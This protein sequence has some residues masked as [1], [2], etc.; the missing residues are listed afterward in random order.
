MAAVAVAALAHLHL[1]RVALERLGKVIMARL[2]LT[3]AVYPVLLAVA[4]VVLAVLVQQELQLLFLVALV[5]LEHH[6]L[7]L[8]RLNFMQA[9]AAVLLLQLEA[10]VGLALAALVARQH[11]AA[12]RLQTQAAVVVVAVA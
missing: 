5:V 12:M 9:V 3:V 11:L 7:F 1:E 6:H 4:V 8:D 2:A 10:L